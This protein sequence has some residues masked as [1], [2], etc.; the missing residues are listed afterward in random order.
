MLLT[1]FLLEQAGMDHVAVAHSAL[2]PPLAMVHAGRPR[3]PVRMHAS[4]KDALVVMRSEVPL[5]PAVA[6]PLAQGTLAWANRR[7]TERIITL[8]SVTAHLTTPHARFTSATAD[9]ARP[10]KA[11]RWK[12]W[13]QA[14]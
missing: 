9:T 13:K 1:D 7:H 8:D 6:R 11:E 14:A 12:S 3:F 2:F 4:Q 5:D 10:R